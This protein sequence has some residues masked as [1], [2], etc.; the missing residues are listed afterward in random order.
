[1]TWATEALSR[2]LS[3]ERWM[4]LALAGSLDGVVIT[5]EGEWFDL[6]ITS[7]FLAPDEHDASAGF[8]VGNSIMGRGEP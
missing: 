4:M 6:R 5:T 3:K 7:T 2:S 1:V 8:P